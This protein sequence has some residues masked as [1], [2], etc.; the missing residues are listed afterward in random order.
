MHLLAV[1]LLT[2]TVA[3]Q[4]VIGG[5]VSGL[6]SA[7]QQPRDPRAALV[8]GK[9]VIRGRVTAAD[10]GAP[11][12][13]AVVTISGTGRRATSTDAEGRY[14]FTGLPAG[15]YTLSASPS[16]FRPT[17][18][19]VLWGSA[20]GTGA[21]KAIKV[22]EAEL[23]DNIDFALPRGGVIAGR[24]LDPYGD[25][26]ARVSVAPLMVRIG[27]EPS[28]TGPTA[29]TDDLGQFRLFGLA[30]G[31][32]LVRVDARMG[33]FSGPP[34]FEGEPVGF[35]TTY[36]PGTPSRGDALR[37]RVPA[38]G[39]VAADIRLVESRIFTVSG[40]VLG[41]NGAP[42]PHVDVSLVH[43]E[44]GSSSSFGSSMGPN[45]TF[46][47]RNVPPGTYEI[48]ARVQEQRP[49]GPPPAGRPM[50][51]PSILEMGAV[52]VDVSTT[53]VENVIVAMRPGETV[54]GEIVFD[55]APPAEFKA[56]VFMQ[57]TDR[58]P[59]Y[60]MPPVTVNGS[61]FTVRDLFGSYILRGSVTAAGGQWSLKAVL[62]DGK[63]VTDM[64]VALSSSHSGR[65]Q[66]V[67]TSRGATLEG[68]VTDDAGNA[69]RDAQIIVFGA[70]EESWVP[71]SS[72]M[73]S[74]GFMR[75]QNTFSVRGLRDGRYYVVAVPPNSIVFG[76]PQPPDRE[77]FNQLKRVATEVVLNP[78]ETRALELRLVRFDQ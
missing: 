78:G 32:Y 14:Q 64:P 31:T 10:T 3:A 17:Y 65:L 49:M 50:G 70:D 29:Q 47:F 43:N 54:T 36:A 74:G 18:R 66:V 26:V 25:P 63:D 77:L 75:D 35:A 20:S 4:G 30:P 72:R 68:T 73:R 53:D 55:E 46:T 48:V 39:E 58:R 16:S 38:G 12:R 41:S 69:T 44:P 61:Q 59:M 76:G 52:R 21:G 34:E 13:R 51:P 7:P 40:A 42:P 27:G 23:I 33:M 60:S 67:F 62:V 37:V 5:T 15:S 8:G 2:T 6:P 1:L 19:S 56:T 28:Q 24:V 57:M 11:M 45:G 9:S 22:G 71:F